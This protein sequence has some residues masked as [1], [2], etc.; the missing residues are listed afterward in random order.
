M[1]T[2]R[3]IDEFKNEPFTDFSLPENKAA[4]E[5]AIEKVRNELGRE[6]PIVVN[7]EKVSIE[8]LV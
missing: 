2:Q 8:K 7:G 5:A 3:T 1:Q 4:I 6:Y